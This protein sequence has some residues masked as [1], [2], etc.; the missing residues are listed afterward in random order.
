MKKHTKLLRWIIFIILSTSLL[1]IPLFLQFNS[2]LESR[3]HRLGD[4]LAL[5]TLNYITNYQQIQELKLP[6]NNIYNIHFNS[7]INGYIAFYQLRKTALNL[8]LMV[9]ALKNIVINFFL[10]CLWI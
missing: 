3:Y 9:K 1:F 6:S 5:R 7:P 2:S 4:G 8:P 10:L